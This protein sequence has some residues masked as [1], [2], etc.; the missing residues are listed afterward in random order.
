MK[1]KTGSASSGIETACSSTSSIGNVQSP[2][3][4][5]MSDSLFMHVSTDSPGSSSADSLITYLQQENVRLHQEVA[6]LNQKLTETEKKLEKAQRQ[7]KLSYQFG[8]Y[9][10]QTRSRRVSSHAQILP[11]SDSRIR[12]LSWSLDSIHHELMRLELEHQA[13]AKMMEPVCAELP[14]VMFN[15]RLHAKTKTTKGHK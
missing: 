1:R 7:P 15:H 13:M 9:P 14:K 5:H 6:R 12:K 3:P 10:V 11:S 4:S 2:P 8:Q